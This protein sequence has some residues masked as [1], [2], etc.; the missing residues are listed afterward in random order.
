M[1]SN[2]YVYNKKPT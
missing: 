2:I 1:L